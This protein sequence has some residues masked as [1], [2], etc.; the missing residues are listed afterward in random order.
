MIRAHLEHLLDHVKTDL[1]GQAVEYVHEQCVPPPS[2]SVQRIE[3]EPAPATGEA[4]PGAS[5]LRQWPI[6]S[7][8]A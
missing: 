6:Q 5:E 8:A 7:P 2:T 4:H 1:Y 3:R